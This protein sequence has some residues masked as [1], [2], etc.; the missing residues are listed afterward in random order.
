MAAELPGPLQVRES[1]ACNDPRCA[2][3]FG[4]VEGIPH[5]A[6]PVRKAMASVTFPTWRGRASV[7]VLNFILA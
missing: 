1:R 6:A 2:A 4:R 5:F 7:P 3:D